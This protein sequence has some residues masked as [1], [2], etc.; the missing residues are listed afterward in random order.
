[1]CGFTCSVAALPGDILSLKR[2][3]STCSHL[4]H[5]SVAASPLGRS[6]HEIIA[7]KEEKEIFLQLFMVWLTL[8]FLSEFHIHTFPLPFLS[9]MAMARQIFAYQLLCKLQIEFSC[10]C[11][12]NLPGDFIA[13]MESFV[14]QL[15]FFLFF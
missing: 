5:Q 9:I 13:F 3:H 14:V 2:L 12:P 4:Y 15:L 7:L 10:L 6:G 1:M 8:F 11:R